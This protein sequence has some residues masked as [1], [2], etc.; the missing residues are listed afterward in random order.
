[1]LCVTP[2]LCVAGSHNGVF[3]SAG[4]WSVVWMNMGLTLSIEAQRCVAA[5]PA[6]QGPKLGQENKLSGPDLGW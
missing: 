2:T 4:D 1:M 5:L 3:S 6:A